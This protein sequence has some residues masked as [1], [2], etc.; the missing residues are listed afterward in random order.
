MKFV[1][2]GFG[3]NRTSW[4]VRSLVAIGGKA[5]MARTSHFGRD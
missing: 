1:T 3:T 5:D 2:S 4:N